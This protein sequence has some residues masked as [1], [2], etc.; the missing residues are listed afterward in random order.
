M[1]HE[2]V[3]AA[4]I[5]LDAREGPVRVVDEDDVG[6]GQ[7]V[8]LRYPHLGALD[9][10]IELPLQPQPVLV[11]AVQ[12]QA[13][14][15]RPVRRRVAGPVE[16]P[17]HPQPGHVPA[18]HLPVRAQ[19]VVS[20]GV[21]PGRHPPAEVAVGLGV[22][23]LDE[24]PQGRRGEGVGVEVATAPCQERLKA[25]VVHQL[26]QRRGALGIGDAV[27]V[28][29]RGLEVGDVG[30]HG[31]GRRHGVGQVATH[32][33]GGGEVHPAVGE[34]AR[35]HRD[36]AAHELGEA[37]LEPEVAPPA[38][39][40]E[41]AEPHVAH[42]VHQG[43]GPALELRGGRGRA[44]QVVLGEGDQAGV[45]HR[46]EV[47]FGDEDLVV[48]DAPRVVAEVGGQP[49]EARLGEPEQLV[50]IEVAGQALPAHQPQLHALPRVDDPVV[51]SRGQAG[52]VGRQGVG[53][54]ELGPHHPV[55]HRRPRRLGLVGTEPPA[56][57]PG[58]GEPEGR[59]EVGLF[60]VGEDAPR[61]GGLVLG[62]EVGLAVG[63]V[64]EAVQ[65]LPRARVPAVGVDGDGAAAPRQPRQR[66]P[67]A[68]VLQGVG[69]AVDE[70]RVHLADEV[71]PGLPRPAGQ[72]DRRRDR[73]GVHGG[74]R[75]VADVDVDLVGMHAH[76]SRPVC[77][78]GPGEVRGRHSPHPITPRL[79]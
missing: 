2:D 8:G 39:G 38:G 17:P 33:P 15:V 64:D 14:G 18:V 61:V 58:E 78:L 9:A 48:L 11:Q 20:G 54:R 19:P 36:V 47:V 44:E 71:Q 73:E 79:S 23:G 29:L 3:A 76:V 67:G 28:R 75:G 13:G 57:R 7:P 30:H 62:V 31:V 77:G 24:V 32:L 70:D 12:R 43:V 26:G 22:Q 52:D 1:G 34:P 45:L 21:Q 25:H 51:G 49:L 42:L 56:L 60:E 55:R 50:G 63:G 37:L 65:P 10:Q 27:E 16:V 4:R 68:V 6:H 66:D 69:G 40:D 72:R 5:Q 46:A 74:V 59:P 41:V 53:G 35:L